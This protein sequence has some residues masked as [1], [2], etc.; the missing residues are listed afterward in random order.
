MSAILEIRTKE[1][2]DKKTYGGNA[3][4]I[5]ASSIGINIMVVRFFPISHATRCHVTVSHVFCLSKYH[6]LLVIIW[7]SGTP[8]FSFDG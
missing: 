1:D 5:T 8:T 2:Y 3:K 7:S 4:V 6:G